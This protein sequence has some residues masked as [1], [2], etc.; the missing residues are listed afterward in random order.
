MHVG[1]TTTMYGEYH[2]GKR[3]AN[4]CQSGPS[5]EHGQQSMVTTRPQRW[6]GLMCSGQAGPECYIVYQGQIPY[7]GRQ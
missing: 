4:G 3:Y 2:R 7:I 1:Q 6:P 5:R